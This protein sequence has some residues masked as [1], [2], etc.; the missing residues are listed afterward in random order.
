MKATVL[1]CE[2]TAEGSGIF[3]LEF[4]LWEGHLKVKPGQFIALQPLNQLSV[5][6]RPF[7]VY[8]VLSE[9]GD[10]I[11]ILFRVVGPNTAA[12][13]KLKLN[14]QIEIFGPR[15]NPIPLDPEVKSYILVGGGIGGAAL[16]L[17]AK[18]L[19]EKGKTVNFL[20]GVKEPS[21]IFGIDELKNTDCHL[22]II[23][24][25]NATHTGMV[26][27]LLEESLA[28]DEGKSTIIACGPVVM[29]KLVAEMAA[30]SGNRCLVL[31]EEIMA[32]G[33][34]GSCKGCVVFGKDG[35]VRYVC[36]D[37]PAF[38]ASWVDW[39]RLMRRYRVTS[40]PRSENVANPLETT[41]VGQN[42]R[43]L[44]LAA[45]I[46]NASG[47]LDIG[48]IEKGWV[49]TIRAG[50]LVTKAVTLGKRSGNEDP[51]VCEVAGGMLN[52]IGLANK[53][54]TRFL[55]EDLPEW[56]KFNLPVI[57]NISGFSV[58]N[59]GELAHQLASTGVAAI[60]IN[61]SCP[62]VAHGG[63]VFGTNP[64]QTAK[65][66]K[67]VRG[68]APNI[69]LIVKLTPAAGIQIVKVAEAAVKAGADALS[70]INTV[71]GLAFDIH[72]GKA[73][74]GA[75]SG[76]LSGPAIL[77]ISLWMINQVFRANLGAPIIGVGGIQD[78]DSAMQAILAGASAIQVGTAL[79]KNGKAMSDIHDF[80]PEMVSYHGAGHI[81][82]LIGQGGF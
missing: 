9:I 37:G 1:E 27:D 49:N 81:R 43:T 30:Q 51:R 56:L 18:E 3:L 71:P 69:F 62:N 36:Q 19:G 22:Q 35:T 70:L 8:S 64:R 79:F 67:A 32:C 55:G 74:L 12:Y 77:P 75:G 28:G 20:L 50:A 52:S 41:L 31:L 48:A 59:Y 21:Q 44:K 34:V 39:E 5:M 54:I 53:G 65:V 61:V 24:E 58:D 29:L 6:R 60:E 13:A 4:Y 68:A 45:P 11:K 66:V 7:S 23:A 73:R 80:L 25:R 26:T 82:D 72:S 40:L 57:V 14:D 10:R 42:G 78:G 16:M 76:G 2:E 47:C 38:D 17:L 63:M 33:G 15:G 46:M